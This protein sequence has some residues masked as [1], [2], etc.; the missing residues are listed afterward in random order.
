MLNWLKGAE[1]LSKKAK[2]DKKEYMKAYED[3]RIR[4][5]NEKWRLDKEGEKIE[6]LIFDESSKRMHCST[7]KS[8]ATAKHKRHMWITGTDQLKLDSI[9]KHQVSD[10]HSFSMKCFEN[11]KK[12]SMQ[13]EA[14]ACISQLTRAQNENV[15]RLMRTAHALAKH[16]APF[17]QF[18]WMCK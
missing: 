1:P 11:S 10:C 4:T 14:G 12:A 13:T 2:N 17:T 9:Q 18:A 16:S 5:F 7:C 15:S 8:F 6:W 3:V